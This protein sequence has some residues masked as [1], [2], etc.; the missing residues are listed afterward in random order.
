M[1][2]KFIGLYR[3]HFDANYGGDFSEIWYTFNDPITHSTL[4]KDLNVNWNLR[5]E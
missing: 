2:P 1:D 3:R 5:L 4:Y